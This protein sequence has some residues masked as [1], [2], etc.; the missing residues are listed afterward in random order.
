MQPLSLALIF[1]KLSIFFPPPAVMMAFLAVSGFCTV[2][3]T[4]PLIQALRDWSWYWYWFDSKFYLHFNGSDHFLLKA[5]FLWCLVN[6]S[7]SLLSVQ[8]KGPHLHI[9]QNI[10]PCRDINSISGDLIATFTPVHGAA[11]NEQPRTEAWVRA[12]FFFFFPARS[13][14][15]IFKVLAVYRLKSLPS[16]SVCLLMAPRKPLRRN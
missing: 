7:F 3:Q 6:I 2:C 13:S 14:I 4:K 16:P 12:C 9:C 15:V 5:L 1:A 8:T 11:K 10:F